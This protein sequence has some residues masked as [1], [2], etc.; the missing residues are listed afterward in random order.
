[1]IDGSRTVATLPQVLTMLHGFHGEALVDDGSVIMQSLLANDP[2]RGVDVA[3]IGVLSRPPTD[4]D[5]ETVSM[6]LRAAPTPLDGFHDVVWALVNTREFLF[7][8]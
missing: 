1:M 4:D 8:Q 5:R 7:I 6:V 2:A 3:F